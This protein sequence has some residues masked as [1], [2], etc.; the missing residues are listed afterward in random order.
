[1]QLA[2][3]PAEEAAK[4]YRLR[5]PP[6][7]P[8]DTHTFFG[9]RTFD[10][11]R[12][13]YGIDEHEKARYAKTPLYDTN[14][15]S[16]ALFQIVTKDQ[17]REIDLAENVTGAQQEAAAAMREAELRAAVEAANARADDAS[18]RATS[19]ENNV[20]SMRN[21][22]DEM[23]RNLSELMAILKGQ[24]PSIKS[25]AET[26]DAVH[27]QKVDPKVEAKPVDKLGEA[28]TEQRPARPGEKRESGKAKPAPK[29]G[30]D[31]E[32]K[33]EPK[34]Q[35]VDGDAADPTGANKAASAY[36]ESLKESGFT[37]NR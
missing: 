25:P 36:D 6:T 20:A 1:M 9:G 10:K 12:R 23:G 19:A 5:I 26:S 34:L 18:A 24:N 30:V 29:T 17:A 22:M 3:M 8:R 7:H 16:P 2:P 32:P 21:Q 28:K 33:Q 13:W 14:P 11:K 4:P 37:P 31:D 35:G 27:E 15:A